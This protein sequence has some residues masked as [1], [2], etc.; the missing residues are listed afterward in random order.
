VG[1]IA[2]DMDLDRLANLQELIKEQTESGY[3]YGAAIKVARHGETVL[4]LAEGFADKDRTQPIRTDSVFSVF[5]ITKCFINVLTL[6]AIEL[7]RFSL[8]TRMSELIPEFSG[9][10]RDRATIFHFLTHTTGM[11][12]VWEPK[13]GLMLDELEDAVSA[14][15]E[16]IHGKQE[17]GERC[18]YAPMANHTLL[19]EVLR[20]TDPAKRSIQQILIEDLLEPLGM[21]DTNL[22]I[23][24]HMRD[25]HVIP[26]MR[27]TVPIT[28]PSRTSPGENGLYT[29]ESNGCTWAGGASTTGDLQKLME[30]L[31]RGGTAANGT[32]VLSPG[33]VELARQVW[34]GDLPNE[35]YKTV[36][37]QRGYAVPPA[38]I[39][40]GF[41]VRGEGVFVT[42]LGNLTS[43]QTF[44]NYGAGTGLVWVDPVRDIS[45]VGL[46]A[47]LLSQSENILR[48]QKISDMVA[49]AAL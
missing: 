11:P 12:G 3:Y 21:T 18:D 43:P 31:R 7:G 49:A 26:D 23:K 9:A 37:L 22:G 15:I 40:L 33:T 24:P 14:V 16:F 17:P 2:A 20:R 42:Q 30:M 44:G 28:S 41:N 10:P 8:T 25:R 32:R 35:L 38:A 5:S 47:G 45:F 1:N 39:G 36:A 13:S 4:D 29:A 19:A 27:G 34:T 46:S 48:Y 6:R